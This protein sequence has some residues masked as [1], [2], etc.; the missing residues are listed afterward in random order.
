MTTHRQRPLKLIDRNVRGDLTDLA[1]QLGCDTQ[2]HHEVSSHFFK[3]K[4]ST[5]DHAV[6]VSIIFFPS[7]TM[8]ASPE[9]MIEVMGRGLRGNG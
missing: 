6:K 5:S 8:E 1:C 3:M 7:F 4:F 2:T 9:S